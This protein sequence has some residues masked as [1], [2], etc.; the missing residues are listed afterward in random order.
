MNNI[1]LAPVITEKSLG[2]QE[3]GYYSLWVGKTATKNQIASAFVSAYN[4]APIKINIV[5]LK[6]KLKTDWKKR[7]PIQKPD[8]KKAIIF[9]G[10]DKKIE[11]LQLKQK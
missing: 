2:L 4:I 8:R 5:S 3:K 9:I 1:I 6:G 7:T 10:K 11:S